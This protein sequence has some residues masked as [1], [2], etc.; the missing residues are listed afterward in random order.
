MLNCVRECENDSSRKKAD[1]VFNEQ[2][3]R[4]PIRCV[5]HEVR[6]KKEFY[7]SVTSPSTRQTPVFFR[8][9]N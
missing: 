5:Y 7:N 3:K 9:I 4:F 2:V 8:E 6:L 1:V